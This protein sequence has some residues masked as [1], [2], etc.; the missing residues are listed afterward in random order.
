M[1]SNQ[2]QVYSGAELTLI[3]KEWYYVS[4][5]AFPPGF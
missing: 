5:V 1:E 4:Y 3:K 2:M